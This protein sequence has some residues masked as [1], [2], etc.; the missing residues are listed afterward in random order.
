MKEDFG[1]RLMELRRQKGYSQEELGG[2][3]FVSRQTISKWELNISTPEM[4]KLL[5]LGD[6]FGIS[7]DELMGYARVIP[8]LDENDLSDESRNEFEV[9]NKKIDHL[10]ERKYH[11]EYKSKKMVGT[12]PLV[13]INIGRGMYRANGIISIGM[14]ANGIV[15]IGL[16]S[17][18]IF[19]F[20]MVSLGLVASAPFALGLLACGSIALGVF[21]CGAIAIGYLSVGAVAVGVYAIG[22]DAHA[23]RI[24]CGDIAHG[25]IAIA[26]SSADGVVTFLTKDM[27]SFEETRNAILR[28]YPNTPKWLVELF[29]KCTIK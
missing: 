19:S 15:S 17:F 1:N 16:F 12:K 7:M 13:H 5:L 9:L 21:A 29:S 11:Y 8:E 10:I 6:V 24:A 14:I 26:K 23:L 3:V 25:H 4:E 18:G 20:G 27:A 22:A 28:E 2:L